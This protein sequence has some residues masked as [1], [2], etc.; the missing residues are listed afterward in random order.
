MKIFAP[1]V[2]AIER[3]LEGRPLRQRMRM[4][5]LGATLALTAIFALSVTL[6]VIDPRRLGRIQHDH[7]PALDAGRGMRETLGNLQHVLETGVAAAD[8]QR[9]AQTDSL[10]SVFED[11][12]RGARLHASDPIEVDDIASRFAGYYALARPVNRMLILRTGGDSLSSAIGRVTTSQASLRHAVDAYIQRE[13][14]AIDQAFSAE[15]ALQ[16]S[17]TF[18]VALIALVAA[19]VLGALSIATT[20]AVTRP[21]DDLAAAAAR[22]A[23]GDISVDIPSA[24][25]DEVGNVSRAMTDVVGYLNE[26]A[27]VAQAVA[28]GDLSHAVK[29]RSEH[30]RFGTAL[31]AM[32]QYLTEMSVTAERLAHGD[33]TVQVMPRSHQDA[34]GH[35]FAA[36]IDRLRTIIAEMR[37][38]AVSIAASAGEM[39][40]SAHELA[41]SS[42]EG[43]TGFRHTVGQISNMSAAVRDNAERSQVVERQALEGAQATRE[44]ARVVQEAIESTREI[45][46][47]T[48]MIESIARQ[49]NLLSLNAAIEAARAGE[50]GR[51]FHV[52]AEEVRKLAAQCAT[53]AQEISRLSVDS[54]QKIEKSREILRALAP[55]IAGTAALVQELAAASSAQASGL[56]DVEQTMLRADDSTRRNAATAEEFAAT[57]EELLAQAERLEEL[58]SRFQLK[59]GML[60]KRQSVRAPRAPASQLVAVV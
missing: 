13:Q 2:R 7:Y 47:R 28:V 53:T 26:M 22:I 43:A 56:T 33:L 24:G 36:M 49:T 27:A 41:V 10:R 58:V 60:V 45:L 4:L 19:I 3:Q 18:G 9:L 11:I 32:V 16:M 40:T 31:A 20:N 34:F 6:G 48:S 46:A 15:R 35:S 1:M 42:G 12:A 57:A 30:D 25:D 38:A 50:H 39:Q 44:G 23:Q 29:R 59:A 52:V 17:A 55:S 21:L 14:T 37:E 5:P 54:E 8:T 51:G